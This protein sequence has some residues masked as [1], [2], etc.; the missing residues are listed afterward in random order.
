MFSLLVLVACG[1]RVEPKKPSVTAIEPDA[2]ATWQGDACV[3]LASRETPLDLAGALIDGDLHKGKTHC[4]LDLQRALCVRYPEGDGGVDEIYV[5][6]LRLPGSCDN[7]A[8]VRFRGSVRGVVEPLGV[9]HPG[10]WTVDATATSLE[11]ANHVVE[12]ELGDAGAARKELLESFVLRCWRNA[13]VA[14]PTIMGHLT[15]DVV[16]AASGEVTDVRRREA[17]AATDAFASCVDK[18]LRAPQM[19]VPADTNASR[20]VSVRIVFSVAVAP[21]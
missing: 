10:E 7:Q 18:S 4:Y 6:T 19:F 15:L 16:V 8:E 12:I 1:V 17:V 3:T 9:N 13:S 21:L 14:S 5:R 20:E 11:R 2:G